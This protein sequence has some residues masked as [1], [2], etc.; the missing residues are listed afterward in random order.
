MIFEVNETVSPA[1]E[2]K[3]SNNGRKKSKN[4]RFLLN[5]DNVDLSSVPSFVF[6]IVEY[7]TKLILHLLGREHL[8]NAANKKCLLLARNLDVDFVL[9]HRLLFVTNFD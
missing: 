3:T 1:S 4:S 2:V 8:V 9:E 5:G 7:P 6:V